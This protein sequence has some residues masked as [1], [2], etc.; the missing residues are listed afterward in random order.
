MADLAAPPQPAAGL[1]H[2]DTPP[3]YDQL[4]ERACITCG[5]AAPPL[6]PAGYRTVGGLTWAVVACADHGA[7]ES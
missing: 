4:H 6:V 7:E 3:T 5:S 1:P 2:A